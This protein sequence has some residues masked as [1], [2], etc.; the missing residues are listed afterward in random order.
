MQTTPD[1]GADTPGVMQ[2]FFLIG[3]ACLLFAAFAPHLLRIGS[4]KVET[5]SFFWPVSF[6][7]AEGLL[8][9][10]YVKFGKFCHR[11]FMLGMDEWQSYACVLD[12]GC[13]R[14]LLL[15]GGAKR[16]AAQKR[17]RTHHGDRHLVEHHMASNSAAATE[18]KLELEGVA[19]I[20][21]LVNKPA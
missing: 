14:G 4:A 16:I 9:L 15:A 1:Y 8:F 5:G 7:I 13:G 12:M 18:R 19:Q 3:F 2:T 10:L 21:T 20:C 11:D 17:R 6:F